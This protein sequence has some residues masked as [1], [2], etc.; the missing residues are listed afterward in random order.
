MALELIEDAFGDPRNARFLARAADLCYFNQPQGGQAL[1]DQLGLEAQLISVNH[2][3]AY[4]CHNDQHLVVAFRGTESPISIDGLKDWFLTNAVNLLILPEG[5]LGTDFVAAGV[6]A[7]FH[8]GFI[9]AL[10][11][12][13]DPVRTAVKDEVKKNDRPLWLTGHSLGGALALLA[14]WLFL[15]NTIDVHQIYTF[16]GPM[17]GNDV[18]SQAINREFP[19]KIFRYIDFQDPIP[20]LPTASLLANSYLHCEKEMGVGETPTAT[21]PLD[22]FKGIVGGGFEGVLSGKPLDDLWRAVIGK[23]EAHSMSNYTKL[24]G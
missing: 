1:R 23:L 15:R 7:K 13:W 10:A 14:G 21:S 17:I 5:R 2:T 3:Q 20:K 16:G 18:A 6:G 22:F 9:E 4:I 12:I 8:Q 11:S 19:N 24:L